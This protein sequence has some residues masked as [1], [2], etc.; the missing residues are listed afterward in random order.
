MCF[1][2]DIKFADWYRGRPV[3]R[4]DKSKSKINAFFSGTALFWTLLPVDAGM[5]TVG[6]EHGHHIQGNMWGPF[7]LLVIGISS[8]CNNLKARKCLRTKENY[9]NLHPEKWADIW[10]LVEWEN[11]ERVYKGEY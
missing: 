7:Y 4:F 8:L 9:Y 2:K 5:R 11:G 3:F 6:H 10:G 1:I